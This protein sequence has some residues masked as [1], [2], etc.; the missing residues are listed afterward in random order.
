[1]IW[2]LQP[3]PRKGRTDHPSPRFTR[4]SFK[5]TKTTSKIIGLIETLRGIKFH[6]VSSK[7]NQQM[8]Q[9]ILQAHLLKSIKMHLKS[10]TICWTIKTLTNIWGSI[11]SV[12]LILREIPQENPRIQHTFLGQK[13]LNTGEYSTRILTSGSMTKPTW[14][15]WIENWQNSKELRFSLKM[16][17]WG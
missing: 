17:F 6:W 10:A 14:R 13:V 8:F 11:N 3:Q 5:I 1:M 4:V 15:S 9:T 12:I 7:P 16:I 2:C